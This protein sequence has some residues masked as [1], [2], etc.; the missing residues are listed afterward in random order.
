[1]TFATDDE[2]GPLVAQT[3]PAARSITVRERHS[4]VELPELGSGYTPRKLDPRVG[5]FG[6][7]F[8]DF[9]TPTGTPIETRWISRHR[10][11][12]KDPTLAVSEPVTPHPLLRRPGRARADPLGPGRGGV[13]V[14]E[15]VRGRRVQGRLPGRGPARGGRPDGPPLQRDPLGPP[16]DPRLVLR[17]QRHRPPDRRDPQGVRRPRL[18]EGPAGRPDRRRAWSPRPRA[19]G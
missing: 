15:G 7:E 17:Q 4:L 19:A 2:P 13:V 6:I 9:A 14:V 16:L 1:M 3:A 5:V 10:L 8:A 18:A 12:K 11:I